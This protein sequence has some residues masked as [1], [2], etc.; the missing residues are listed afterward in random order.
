MS[1]NFLFKQHA[2]I[3][4]GAGEIIKIDELLSSLSSKGAIIACDPFLFSLSEKIKNASSVIRD[5]F[6][7]IEPN[8]QVIGVY[9]LLLML[10]KHKADTIVAIGGG[11]VMDT[12]KFSKAVYCENISSLP[13]ILEYYNLQIPFRTSSPINVIA[14]P[15]T[16]GTGAEVTSVAVISNGEIKNTFSSPAFLPDI[17]VVDPELTLTV[18]KKVTMV[19]GLDALSHALESFWNI[20]HQPITDMYAKE[21]IRLIFDN[22]EEAYVNGSNLVARENMSY[23]ALLAGLAFSQTRTAGCHASS[24]PLSTYYHLPHGEACA[25]TLAGFIKLNRDLRLESLAIETGFSSMDEMANKIVYFQRLAGLKITLKDAGITDTR[26]L[27][28]QCIEHQLMRLNPVQ[29]SIEQMEALFNS[30]GI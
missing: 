29:P 13:I 28:T 11:S 10:E 20:N 30:L 16:A 27:A 15:T 21:A 9:N 12:A 19:T 8:P 5:V 23:A 14:V 26:I 3:H 7:D 22:L 1:Y 25:F 2:N 4:F 18:P 6:S 17:C 24:Y